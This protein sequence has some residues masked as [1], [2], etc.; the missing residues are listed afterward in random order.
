VLL[1]FH[2]FTAPLVFVAYVPSKWLAM[3]LSV[4]TVVTYWAMNEVGGHCCR[5][6]CCYCCRRG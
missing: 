1:L 4:V 5:R 3:L 2:T 6:G